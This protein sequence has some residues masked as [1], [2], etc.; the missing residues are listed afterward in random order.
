M[1]KIGVGHSLRIDT[2]EAVLEATSD[3][4]LNGEL[5]KA[6]W[7]L[8][9]FTTPHLHQAELI[10]QTLVLQTQC[11]N[12]AGCSGAG[13]LTQEE[14]ISSVPGLVVM[15]GDTPELNPV[16]FLKHQELRG[17]ESPNRQLKLMLEA[18]PGQHPILCVF[19]DAYNQMPYNLINTLNYVK[20]KPWV[21]GAGACDDGSYQK[22]AQ[23]DGH[24]VSYKGIS[25]ICFS[26]QA[27]VLVGV[28]QSCAP[29]AEPMFITK[30]RENIIMTLDSFPALEVFTTIAANLGFKDLESAARQVLVGFP[31]DVENPKFTGESVLVRN[32]T[33]IDVN[34]GGLVVPQMVQENEILSF[35][36][37]SPN[38]AEQ[39]LHN[40]LEGIKRDN[41]NTP[42]FGL[43]FNCAARGSALYGKD[44]VDTQAIR[45]VLGEFPLIG[46]FGGF[47]LASGDLGLQLYSYTGVLV[48][49]Y[50]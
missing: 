9:F 3:A 12:V 34:G 47:E 37:R 38:T 39:D 19:P 17:S 28:T 27:K 16:C 13:V 48:L 6:Q 15:V 20:T 1:F 42:A 30:V 41:P 26:H 8:V 11:E 24:A 44:N 46:F 49:F 50:R 2:E 10:R 18:M 22:A 31:L 32:L 5:S 45:D 7:A 33:G 29:V 21:F 23:L 40:M 43:Y 25:G 36:Y 4:M 35:L 14:E